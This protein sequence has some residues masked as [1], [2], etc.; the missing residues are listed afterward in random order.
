[1]KRGLKGYL[2]LILVMLFCIGCGKAD[3]DAN[4]KEITCV[5]DLNGAKI[6]VQLG[7]VADRYAT[8]YEGDDEGTKVERFNKSAEAIQALKQKK[9]DCVI[10]DEQPAKKFVEDES[11]L[12]ILD[13]AFAREDY[14][15][16]IAKGNDELVTKVNGALDELEA[17]GT[18]AKITANYIGDDTKGSFQYESPDGIKYDNGTLVVAT[19][20]A[21]PPYEYYENGEVTGIDI[22]LVRAIGDKLGMKIEIEEMEFD[23][24]INAVNSK[25]ADLGVSGIS[26]TAER[27]KAIN[28]S[29]AYTT[30]NQVIIVSTSEAGD[31]SSG[32]VDDIKKCFVDDARWQY[33]VKG[34]CNTII[35]AVCAVAIGLLLGFLVAVIRCT[36]D[37]NNTLGFLNWICKVYLT[38]T[39]GTP[40]MIQLLIIYYII[41]AS[42]NINKIFVAV[43]AFGI[44]SGAYVAEIMRGGIMSIDD[45]QMEAGRSLG[46]TYAHT[47]T[48]IIIPQAIKNALPSLANEFISLIKE[49]SICG[50]IGLLDLTRGGDIIRSITYEAFLPLI[51]VALIYLALVQLLTFAVG[52]LERGLRKNEQ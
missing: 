43:I 33:I 27:E 8:D 50:Y 34:L 26:K 1:M 24:I 42:V 6:G 4:T 2:L 36:H 37:K 9:I 20:A 44:N 7:T 31:S 15:I 13:D 38:V 22:D 47:M 49:T 19:N 5:D 41:F 39:R 28:F 45:G 51:A 52:K 46:F 21:F 18:I 14:A 32:I 25:K 12:K 11:S 3:S 40:M 29:R 30:A 23:S 17:E 16:C 35:I 48:L 10:V